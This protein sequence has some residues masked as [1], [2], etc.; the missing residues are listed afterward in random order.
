MRSTSGGSVGVQG[1]TETASWGFWLAWAAAVAF[2]VVTTLS[3]PTMVGGKFNI[4]GEMNRLMPRAVYL[5]FQLVMFVTGPVLMLWLP[6]WMAKR[7]SAYLRLPN[8]DYWLAPEN[9]AKTAAM[10]IKQGKELTIALLA[11]SSFKHWMVVQAHQQATPVLD[12][13]ALLVG[14]VVFVVGVAFWVVAKYF[15]WQ[16]PS[17]DSD[18]QGEKQ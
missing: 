14:T 10:L 3:M 15:Q 6:P 1:A 7:G 11:F 9:R 5:S 17:L 13:R 4:A 2:L 12:T 18:A 8:K 16:P